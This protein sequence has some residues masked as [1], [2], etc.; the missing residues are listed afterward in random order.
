MGKEDSKN[1]PE[2]DLINKAKHYNSGKGKCK[3]GERIECIEIVKYM[4]FNIGNVVK[5]VWR[6]DL[7]NGTEDLKKALYYLETEIKMRESEE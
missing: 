7:K 1:I 4:G 6:A 2:F 3:C 5:Y